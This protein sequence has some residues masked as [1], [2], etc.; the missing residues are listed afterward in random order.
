VQHPASLK[1]LIKGFYQETIG[2]AVYWFFGIGAH[3]IDKRILDRYRQLGGDGSFLGYPVTHNAFGADGVGMFRRFEHGVIYWHPNI[4]AFEVHGDILGKWSALG[5]EQSFLGYPISD[6]ISTQDG[7]RVS[8]FQGGSIYWTS[9]TLA[10]ETH[11]TIRDRW[12]SLGAEISYLGYPISD[13]GDIPSGG[14]RMSRF[15]NGI[16][17]AP[18]GGLVLDVPDSIV[19][20]PGPLVTE[21]T[22]GGRMRLVLASNGDWTYEGHL[23]N[24]G[25]FGLQVAIGTVL[26]T[27]APDGRAFA[28]GYEDS[29]DGT[30]SPGSERTK[31][32]KQ[33]NN[34]PSIRAVWPAIRSTGH[35]TKI[36]VGIGAGEVI[37]LVMSGLFVVG[38]AFFWLSGGDKSSKTCPDGTVVFF[39]TGDTPPPCP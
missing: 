36:D 16:I 32:W 14:G 18:F 21:E 9:E 26:H 31:F 6:E 28:F 17:F 29:L 5:A 27:R 15:Q 11:G 20:D 35:T 8:H 39:N 2:G 4:G 22:V 12:V 13:E 24:S 19:I 30:V 34:N 38:T 23:H 3:F 33:G 7:G 10:F 1:S 25:F 37:Q